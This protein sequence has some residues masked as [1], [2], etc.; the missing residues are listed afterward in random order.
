MD[1]EDSISSKYEFPSTIS[2]NNDL[3]SAGDQRNV[4]LDRNKRK[5][6]EILD[7]VEISVNKNDIYPEARG[8]PK[9]VERILVDKELDNLSSSNLMKGIGIIDVRIKT[10]ERALTNWKFS[11]DEKGLDWIPKEISHLKWGLVL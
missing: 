3:R 8:I 5:K 7:N 2:G 6:M 9:D 11:F 1:L 10:T 4:E